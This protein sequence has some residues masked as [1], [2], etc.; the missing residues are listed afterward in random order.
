MDLDYSQ[1]KTFFWIFPFPSS[2]EKENSEL[3]FSIGKC[4]FL[5]GMSFFHTLYVIH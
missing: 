5:N 4:H 2:P 3:P 1:R